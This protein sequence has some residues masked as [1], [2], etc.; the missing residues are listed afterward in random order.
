MRKEYM[1]GEPH[2]RVESIST[3]I[4]RRDKNYT[5]SY[6]NG[7]TFHGFV[8]LASGSMR[9]D[10]F[11]DRPESIELH[12]DDLIF[13][14]KGCSYI[15]H[16]LEDNTEI[17]IIQFDII[18][19]ELP[20]CL[21]RPVKLDLTGK[22]ETVEAFFPITGKTNRPTLY[23]L[24]CLYRLLWETEDL[25]T[26]PKAKYRKLS[27]AL[28]AISEEIALE[29]PVSYYSELSEMSEPNFRRLFRE[30]TGK[31]PIEYRN[32]LRLEIARA[33]IQSD[34][35]NVSEAAESVGFSNLSFFIRLYKKKY[36]HT[37]K[38]G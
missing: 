5:H 22:K 13:I 36:G 16:Y 31:S 14:P 35:Y 19:G 28:A 29:R 12:R 21:S 34:E 7:R 32:D 25:L 1:P 18:S 37:P 33:R 17:R 10:F 20:E 8:Y 30:Y 2:V 15:S 23:Y 9:D 26:R 11:G 27:K 24:S 38:Q 3:V 6:K 4:V